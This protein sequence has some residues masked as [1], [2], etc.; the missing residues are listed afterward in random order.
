MERVAIRDLRNYA[1]QVGERI[2]MTV[3][4]VP[5]AQLVPLDEGTRERSVD[6]LMATGLLLAR[7]TLTPARAAKPVRAPAGRTSSQ[8]LDE[9]ATAGDLPGHIGAAQ[10]IRRRGRYGACP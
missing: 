8:I 10:E 9:H 6:D 4:G 2:I 7:R 5:A 3:D 1:S